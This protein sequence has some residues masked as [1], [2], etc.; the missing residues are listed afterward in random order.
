MQTTSTI[1]SSTPPVDSDFDQLLCEPVRKRFT[2]MGP[3]ALFTTGPLSY[4]LFL[5]ALPA[6]LRQQHN[7]R[8]CRSFVEHFGGLVHLAPDGTA[9]SPFWDES[10]VPET[11]APAIRTLRVETQ[12]REIVGVFYVSEPVLGT[13]PDDAPFGNPWRHF[14]VKV[15]EW[16]RWSEQ[17]QRETGMTAGQAM[18]Q[19]REEAGMLQRALADYTPATVALAIS[20]LGADS[21]YRGE[22][23]L[24]VARWFGELQQR[25]A[26]VANRRHRDGLIWAAVASAPIGYAHVRSSMIGTLLDDLAA[27]LPVDEVRHKFAAKMHPL[28]YQRPTAPPSAG[29]IREAEKVIAQHA[30][31]GSLARRFAKLE[32]LRPLWIPRAAVDTSKATGRM[33]VFGHLVK[34]PASKVSDIDATHMPMTWEKFARVVLSSSPEAV[35]I[36]VP[37]KGNF[38][39]LITAVHPTAPPMLQWD[40]EDDRNPLSWYVYYGGSHASAWHLSIGWQPLT[41]ITLQPNMYRAGGEHHGTGVFFVIKGAQDTQ[42]RA[43]GGMFVESMRSEFHHI[44]STLEA[45]FKAAPIEGRADATACGLIAQKSGPWDVRLRVTAGNVRTTYKLDRWD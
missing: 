40:R 39:A 45:F 11:F 31:A 2:A 19:R 29:N 13:S 8:A 41:A 20:L 23:V 5:E 30:A 35:D 3:R 22:K 12:R 10:N 21:L 6:E 28:Q 1:T 43:G 9:H 33:S 32:D 15:P 26:S 38:G 44:R 14:H 25:L 24:G 27:G 16:M 18:A 34:P 4:D 42:H 37:T 17:R 36:H 7:C